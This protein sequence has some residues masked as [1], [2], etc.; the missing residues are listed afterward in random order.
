MEDSMG[1]K[2]RRLVSEKES[3]ITFVKSLVELLEK[4]NFNGLQLSWQYPVCAEV[5]F[6]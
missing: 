5:G 6:I 2:W 3:R 4:W 1:D